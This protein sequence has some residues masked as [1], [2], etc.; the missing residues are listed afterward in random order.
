MKKTFPLTA[1]GKADARV[2]DKIR[3]ELNNYVRREQ[4]KTPPEGFNRWTFECRIGPDAATAEPRPLKEL[5][6]AIDRVAETGATSVYLEV[7]ARPDTRPPAR[8]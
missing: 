5:A 3:Q 7:V 1:P 6:G 2:R 4:A 8:R